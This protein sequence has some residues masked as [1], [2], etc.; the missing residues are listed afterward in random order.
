MTVF[1]LFLFVETGGL[2]IKKSNAPD[3]T[4]KKA[5]PSVG[6]LCSAKPNSSDERATSRL[7]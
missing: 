5:K 1:F 7:D 6:S 2:K 3:S 4:G